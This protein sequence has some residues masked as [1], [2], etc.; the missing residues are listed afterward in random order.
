MFIIPRGIEHD[1]AGLSPLP[2]KFYT[3]YAPP[4]HPPGKKQF[5]SSGSKEDEKAMREQVEECERGRVRGEKP[6]GKYQPTKRDLAL[7]EKKVAADMRAAREVDKALGNLP[8]ISDV[9]SGEYVALPTK[10]SQQ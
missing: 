7:M 4:E 1:V 3:I 8:A 6:A 9:Q 10:S 2:A 5:S